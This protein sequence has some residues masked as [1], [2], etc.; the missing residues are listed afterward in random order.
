[1]PAAASGRDAN[2]H[3][4]APWHR[5]SR[6]R[7]KIQQHLLDFIAAD[8]RGRRRLHLQLDLHAVFLELALQQHERLL[9]ELSEIGGLAIVPAVAGEAEHA[10]GDFFRAV[11]RR[12]F[13]SALYRAMASSLCRKP[14]LA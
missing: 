11:R 8:E 3:T 6:V 4:A 9:D 13:L 14:S 1:M 7:E 2:Q 10:V 5:L 12:G